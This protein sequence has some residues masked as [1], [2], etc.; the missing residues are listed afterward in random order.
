MD[1]LISW[2]NNLWGW[3]SKEQAALSGLTGLATVAGVVVAGV[4]AALTWRLAREAK[5]QASTT[6]RMF[7][8]THRPWVEA[9]FLADES[10]F[11]D[12]DTY[13]FEIRLT[14]HGPVP[15]FLLGYTFVVREEGRLP[16]TFESEATWTRPLYPG[17]QRLLRIHHT[18][19]L[20]QNR[21][22]FAWRRSVLLGEAQHARRMVG[23]TFDAGQSAD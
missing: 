2:W 18:P 6:Q 9:N 16:V 19:V 20:R 13:S 23:G 11:L 4:Y 3:L 10:F 1:S 22:R 7:D 15:A 5:R 17:H 8:A 21:V 14:T 12:A